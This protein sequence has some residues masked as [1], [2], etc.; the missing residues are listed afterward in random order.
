MNLTKQQQ[1]TLYTLATAYTKLSDYWTDELGEFMASKGLL[2]QRDLLEAAHEILHT[3][4]EKKRHDLIGK[5]ARIIDPHSQWYDFRGTIDSWDG[6][7]FHIAMSQLT[8]P[9]FDRNQFE[10]IPVKGGVTT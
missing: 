4:N 6:E 9:I 8:F 3:L 7:H 1:D 10:V 2:P 5:K